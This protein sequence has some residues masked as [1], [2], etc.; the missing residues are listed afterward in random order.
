[1]PSGLTVHARETVVRVRAGLY[2]RRDPRMVVRTFIVSGI[3]LFRDGLAELL[4]HHPMT[5]VLGTAADIGSAMTSLEQLRPDVVLVDSAVEGP[6]HV[7]AL[8]LRFPDS[9]VVALGVPETTRNVIPWAE[10]GVA[11][12]VA[13]EGS[14]EDLVGA[15]Q[16]AAQGKL[17][18]ASHIA[19]GLLQRVGELALR[20]P[21]R[22]P[23][24][25]LTAR[26]LDVLQLLALGHSN[27]EI[28]R[29]LSIEVPTVKNHVHNVLEKLGIRRR[30]QVRTA[31]NALLTDVIS[32]ARSASTLQPS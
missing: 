20:A 13:R 27:K 7:R 3:R 15:I 24:V 25:P 1:M 16:D 8:T 6:A 5:E 21:A 26:E 19:A 4:E 28:A 31:A 18:C 29:A 30:T 14:I 9:K 2:P 23:I 17:H 12:Y 32:R 10:A 22:E 11:G